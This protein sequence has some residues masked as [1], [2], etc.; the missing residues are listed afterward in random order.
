MI[1]AISADDGTLA[2]RTLRKKYAAPVARCSTGT[3]TLRYSRSMHSRVSVVCCDRIS[4]TDRAT[5]M[6]RAPVDGF[7]IGQSRW[8]PPP[9]TTDERGFAP[10]RE[11]RPES[12][13]PSADTQTYTLVGLRRSLASLASQCAADVRRPSAAGRRMR[14]S[15]RHRPPVCRAREPHSGRPLAH[16]CA[17]SEARTTTLQSSSMTTRAP[18]LPPVSLAQCT[19]PAAS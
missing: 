4:A 3:Y 12:D 17:P 16:S 14:G 11:Q 1:G 9:C 7:P 10:Q 8:P 13:L 19:T 15:S 2:P 6:A 18:G 5:F